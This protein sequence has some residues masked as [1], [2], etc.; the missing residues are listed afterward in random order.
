MTLKNSML[1]LLT[2]QTSKQ[3]RWLSCLRRGLLRLLADMI[4]G[5]TLPTGGFIPDYSLE[6]G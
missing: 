2:Q 6:T 3:P 5:E 4:T 1:S